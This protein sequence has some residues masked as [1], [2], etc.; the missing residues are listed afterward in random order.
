MN[1]ALLVTRK[2]SYKHFPRAP[3]T[4]S[5]EGEL[6]SCDNYYIKFQLIVLKD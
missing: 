6:C 1:A 5:T 3:L 2:N 4:V